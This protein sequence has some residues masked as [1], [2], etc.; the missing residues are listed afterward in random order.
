MNTLAPSISPAG[1][2]SPAIPSPSLGIEAALAARIIRTTPLPRELWLWLTT[3]QRAA[4]NTPHYVDARLTALVHEIF[5]PLVAQAPPAE[6]QESHATAQWLAVACRAIADHY[7]AVGLGTGPRLLAASLLPLYRCLATRTLAEGLAASRQRLAESLAVLALCHEVGS[8]LVQ[9]LDPLNR[10]RDAPQVILSTHFDIDLSLLAQTIGQA[11]TAFDP[12]SGQFTAAGISRLFRLDPQPPAC[13][14]ADWAAPDLLWRLSGELISQN[15]EMLLPRAWIE[16]AVPW[17]SI[18]DHWQRLSLRLARGP[19]GDPA[20]DT[21]TD[22]APNTGPQNLTPPPQPPLAAEPHMPAPAAADTAA[23]VLI[24]EVR[25]HNDPVFVNVIRRQ[26]AKCRSDDRAV[27]LAS[28]VVQPEDGNDHH[29]VHENGL[30]LWQQ[31]LVNWLAEHP[32]VVEPHAFLTSAGELLLCLLDLERNETT[33]LIRFGLVEVL[34][35]KPVDERDGNCLAKVHVPARYHAGIASTSSPG[36]GF[37]AEQ[38]IGPAMR[39][40]AAA[41]LHGKASIKSIEVY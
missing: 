25:S 26:I 5:E 20:S 37:S 40:L 1:P 36:A 39:C 24:A 17:H 41:S 27:S 7:T 11:V 9:L 23:R 14:L 4:A 19:S 16:T 35:G 3:A 32:Q 13:P 12:A 18:T 8:D 15:S 29:E 34:T 2:W 22:A 30:L 33:S 31:R 38:L 6:R 21:S 28:I 10:R